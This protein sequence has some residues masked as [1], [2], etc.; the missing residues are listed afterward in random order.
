MSVSVTATATVSVALCRGVPSCTNDVKVVSGQS[1][2]LGLSQV[3]AIRPRARRLSTQSRCIGVFQWAPVVTNTTGGSAGMGPTTW[4]VSRPS[5]ARWLTSL[6]R[7]SLSYKCRTASQTEC[8]SEMSRGGPEPGR[9]S[10]TRI[11]SVVSLGRVTLTWRH[12][13]PIRPAR[14]E[15]VPLGMQLSV[16]CAC[17]SALTARLTSSSVM[18]APPRGSPEYSSATVPTSVA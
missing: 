15:Y 14:S 7:D 18:R 12:S 1:T 9:R 2:G 6:G 17:G 5:S 10:C 11:A 16:K 4:P 13:Y 3:P 8:Q